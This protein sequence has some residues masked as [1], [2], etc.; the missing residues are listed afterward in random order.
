MVRRLFAVILSALALYI[1]QNIYLSAIVTVCALYNL[2][3]IVRHA[4]LKVKTMKPISMDKEMLFCYSQFIL[5]IV[6]FVISVSCALNNPVWLILS[7]VAII[8]NI[9]FVRYLL[10]KK[11]KELMRMQKGIERGVKKWVLNSIYRV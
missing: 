3:Y 2:Y 9:Y 7:F 5:S 1:S 8:I 11:R 4:L 6:A 10:T